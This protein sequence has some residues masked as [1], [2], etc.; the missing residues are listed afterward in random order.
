V[1]AG[2][3]VKRY[4]HVIGMATRDIEPGQHVHTH[5]LAM[6]EFARD[7]AFGADRKPTEFAG[8]PA[9][10]QGIVRSVNCSAT[11]ARAIAD[12]FRRDI[13]PEALAD[14]PNVD[15]VVALTHGY[16]CG[17]DPT[18]LRHR[19]AAAHARGLRAAPELRVGA[20]DRARLRGEPDRRH[21]AGARP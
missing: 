6:A 9:T 3:P 14:Y 5:S 19:H 1:A 10:F 21:H 16:G 11:V 17:I 15:G 20:D 2:Q 8:A 18:G 12:H 4:N 7:Y 13:R